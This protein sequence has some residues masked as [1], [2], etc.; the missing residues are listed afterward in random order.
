MS[1]Y[2]KKYLKY[3]M[4]YL[5]LLGGFKKFYVKKNNGRDGTKYTNQCMWI[6]IL[7]YINGYLE[8]DLNLDQIRQIASQ[9]NAQINGVNEML[10]TQDNY[11]SLLNV[12]YYFGLQIHM[13]IPFKNTNNEFVISDEPNWIFGDV[14]SQNVVSILSYCAHFTLIT[15]IDGNKLYN[16]KIKEYEPYIPDNELALGKKINIKSEN[17]EKQL[18]DTLDMM[19]IYNS[20][21]ENFKKTIKS[22]K[23]QLEDLEKSYILNEKNINSYDADTQIAFISSLQEHE[24][25]LKHIIEETE[26]KLNEKNNEIKEIEMLLNHLIL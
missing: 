12:A 5:N 22:S 13:Y 8:I 6:S 9:R 25:F 24:I 11:N 21:I 10:D 18:N 2:K 16:D 19:N 26:N 3:K 15:S 20:V 7:Q 23:S 17:Q 1:D 14:Y 4:K